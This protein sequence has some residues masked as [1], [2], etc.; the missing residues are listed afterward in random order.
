M[1]NAEF[2]QE[3]GKIYRLKVP[4]EE[5]YTSVFLV[6]TETGLVLVDCATTAFDVDEYI[7]PALNKLGFNLSD[8]SMLVLT[9]NHCDHAGGAFRIKELFP[10]IKIAKDDTRL[11]DE[12]TLYPIKGHTRD[13]VG[14]FDLKSGTLISGDGI[15]GLGV[16]K[17]LCSLEDSEEYMKSLTSILDDKKIR[18]I[19][20][21]HAYEPWKSDKALGRS[22]VEERIIFCLKNLER[23]S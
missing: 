6:K 19:L 4:F 18:N 20:F 10:D 7:I 13:F 22:A 2:T 3:V 8:V 21:S 17:Y 23:E 15:Q 11:C 9:H 1:I 5:L 16:G 14:V 12:L